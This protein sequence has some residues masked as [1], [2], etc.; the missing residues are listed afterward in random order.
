MRAVFFVIVL[1]FWAAPLCG[2]EQVDRPVPPITDVIRRAQQAVD[3]GQAGPSGSPIFP[4]VWCGE[5]DEE[6]T[7]DHCWQAYRASLS[8]YETGL[9]HR[10][11]VFAWQHFSTRIIFF[12][13]LGLVVV[14]VYFAWVQF[15]R[16]LAQQAIESPEGTDK[17]TAQTGHEVE[18]SP[19]GI[20]VSSP[21]LGVV[22]LALSLAFFYLYLVYVYPITEIF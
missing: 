21:V 7:R 11:R 10:A 16:G 17:A 20:R 8:Y 22:I 18:I 13:V 3:S 2:Q 12:V 19:K 14:G 1:M 6:A 5:I 4:Q 15:R 9:E